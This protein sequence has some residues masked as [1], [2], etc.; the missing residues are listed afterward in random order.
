MEDS[1]KLLLWGP[2]VAQSVERPT[3][4][5]SSGHDLM[6]R[7]IEPRVGLGN[8]S[9]EPAWDSLSAPP[10]FVRTRALS[11]S[12]KMLV[13]FCFPKNWQRPVQLFLKV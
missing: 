7:G 1:R 3:L 8:D 4:D 12:L 13:N 10:L 11:L 2:W 6:V 9:E 5:F